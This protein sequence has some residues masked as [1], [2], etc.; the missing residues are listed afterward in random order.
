MY[1]EAGK[2]V[3]FFLLI[4]E[5]GREKLTELKQFWS[6]ERQT[7]GTARV[8]G[9]SAGEAGKDEGEVRAG[10]GG[11]E[12]GEGGFGVDS[13]EGC[14]SFPPPLPFFFSSFFFVLLPFSISSMGIFGYLAL[15]P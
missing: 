2:G 1:C 3:S 14:V 8:A 7:Q 12:G 5:R 10:D 13:E 4:L 9:Q 6:F 15:N 11:C